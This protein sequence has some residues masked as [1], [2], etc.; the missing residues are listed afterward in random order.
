MQG[1]YVGRAR[2]TLEYHRGLYAITLATRDEAC[3][4]K[5][6]YTERNTE[7]SVAPHLNIPILARPSSVARPWRRL[8]NSRDLAYALVYI[9][10]LM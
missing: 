1:A 10:D 8:A 5:K 9:I 3:K 7:E 4:K 2:R 6:A